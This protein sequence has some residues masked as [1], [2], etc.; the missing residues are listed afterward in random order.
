MQL[1]RKEGTKEGCK[2]DC[3]VALGKTDMER[4]GLLDNSHKIKTSREEEK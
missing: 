3:G 2:E 4:N 1:G